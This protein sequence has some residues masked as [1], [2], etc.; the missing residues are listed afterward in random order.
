MTN[1]NPFYTPQE[2][3]A[4]G[5]FDGGYF[6]DDPGCIPDH[7]VVR[8]TNYFAPRVGSSR[9]VWE[10]SGWIH[11]ADPLGWFQWY[12][13]YFQ[14]RRMED[15]ARQIARW[16]SFGARHGAQV[17]KYGGANIKARPRQRQGLLHWSHNP[18][19]DFPVGTMLVLP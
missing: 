16:A 10:A 18:L 11:G 14:G 12:C 9:S 6:A 1:F 15:D 3:L 19:P 13:R 17:R 4:L 8:P 5:V 2:M 7:W